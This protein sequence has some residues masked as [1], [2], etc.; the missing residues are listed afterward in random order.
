MR[1]GVTIAAAGK[2]GYIPLPVRVA[3]L[4]GQVFVGSIEGKPG[5]A[6]VECNLFKGDLRGMATGA[7]FPQLTAMGIRMTGCAARILEQIASSFF[8]RQRIGRTMAGRAIDHFFMQT[9]QRKSGLV[10]GELFR[11]PIDQIKIFAQMLRMAS[12]AA[13]GLVPMPATSSLD[14]FG[15]VAMTGQAFQRVGLFFQRM[16]LRAVVHAGQVRMG[17][18]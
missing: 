8:P 16:T 2:S 14:S 4:A 17:S 1:I 7:L 13:F 11:I 18:T 15:Q 9:G 3:S 6:M 5:F 12:D 10:M